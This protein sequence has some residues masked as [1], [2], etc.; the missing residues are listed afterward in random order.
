V[1]NAARLPDAV[2]PKSKSTSQL[3]DAERIA[4]HVL[5][6]IVKSLELAP[7]TE[8]VSIAM[9]AVPIFFSVTAFGFPFEP[10]AILVQAMLRGS[11]LT[12]ATLMQPVS[13]K[14]QG[15]KSRQRMNAYARIGLNVARRFK[16]WIES[17]A[18]EIE[19]KDKDKNACKTAHTSRRFPKRTASMRQSSHFRNLR[20]ESFPMF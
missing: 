11:R 18:K 2:G 5:L 7:E 16:P 1:S 4:S 19:A 10:M 14:A 8:M 15:V 12:P 17:T 13:S 20:V 3:V 9:A 6:W